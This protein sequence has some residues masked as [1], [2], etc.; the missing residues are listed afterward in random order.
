M[1]L[2]QLKNEI[3][4]YC[5]NRPDVVACYLYGSFAAGTNRLGSD[6]DIAVLLDD[7]MPPTA[8]NDVRF[9]IIGELGRIC[10]LD[11]HPLIMNTAGELVLGQVFRKGVCLYERDTETVG[12]FRRRKFPQIAEFTYYIEMMRSKLRQRHGGRLHG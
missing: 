8:Y 6:L 9:N 5:S 3:T 7:A 11:V 10:R 1:D 12:S 2:D 4:C